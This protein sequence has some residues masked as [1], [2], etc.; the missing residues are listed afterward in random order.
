MMICI[1]K[2]GI[3][4]HG[5]YTEVSD[6]DLAMCGTGLD[7]GR[8]FYLSS[9]RQQAL[10]YIPASVR[11]AKRKGIVSPDFS[12]CDGRVSVFRLIPDPNLFVHYFQDAD[13]EWLH[14][15]ACNRNPVLFPELRKKYA[16]V[17]IIGGKVADDATAR[18]LNNYVAGV[19][20]IPGSALADRTAINLLLPE[21][22]KDQ[23]CFRT[24]EAVSALEFQRSVRYGDA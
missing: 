17:D 24:K 22:L 6:I 5:S 9:S 21:R 12:E 19:F 11:K 8:G 13:A 10:S 16:A 7:F 18:V 2:N 14:F 15:A 4:Y 3:L 1:P 20:G 23:F